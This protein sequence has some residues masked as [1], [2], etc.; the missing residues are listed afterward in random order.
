MFANVGDGM[1]EHLESG[2]WVCVAV[3]CSVLQCVAVCCSVSQCVAVCCIVLHR[4]AMG[5]CMSE[6]LESESWVCVA[7]CCSVLQCVAVFCS[8]WRY[9]RIFREWS[10]SVLQCVAVCCSV[11]QC[12]AVLQGVALDGVTSEHSIGGNCVFV[13][14]CCSVALHCSRWCY[15]RLFTEREL[16][17]C[18][19]V[20]Q[21]AAVCCSV[22]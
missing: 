9:V 11:L 18:C 4:T 22:L 16:G 6:S 1:S 3:W 15:V 12:V 21:C 17:L 8:G 10:C 5:D 2:S 19:S 13:A 14:V 20:L 7:V